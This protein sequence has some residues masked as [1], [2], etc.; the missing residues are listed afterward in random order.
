MFGK[1]V[2]KKAVVALT[3]ANSIEDPDGGDEKAYFEG[4]LNHWKDAI[5]DF[6]RNDPELHLDS[7]LCD[8]PIPPIDPAGN[9]RNLIL[10]T[11]NNWLS[12]LWLKCFLAMDVEQ[13]LAFFLIN[14]DRVSFEGCR[15]IPPAEPDTTQ[16]VVSSLALAT[17]SAIPRIYL[18]REQEGRFWKK[19]MHII[20][21]FLKE[22]KK[23]FSIISCVGTAILIG[24]LAV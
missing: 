20:L 13:S 12:E 5:Y 15:T 14:K 22:H 11:A 3:F 21:D 17:P 24:L 10:P 16:G 6:L 7:V 9:Y 1:E 23:L 8:P 19:L 4:E 18:N 2:W